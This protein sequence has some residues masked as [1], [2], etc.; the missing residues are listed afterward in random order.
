MK[1]EFGMSMMSEL[2]FFLGL[3]IIQKDDGI[4]IHQ[5]KFTKDLLKRFKID[6]ARSMAT[7]LHPSTVIDKDKK[8]NYTPEKEYRGMIGS[9][10]YLTASK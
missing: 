3:Q 6:E 9:L 2:K 8:G 7:L 4:F 1:C 5:E 10:L